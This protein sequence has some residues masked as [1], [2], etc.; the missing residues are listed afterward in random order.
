MEDISIKQVWEQALDH[1]EKNLDPGKFRATFSRTKPMSYKDGVFTIAAP[2]EFDKKWIL[3]SYYELTTETISSILGSETKLSIEVDESIIKK[4]LKPEPITEED[5]DEA[6]FEFEQ[7]A[8]SFQEPEQDEVSKILDSVSSRKSDNSKPL[9]KTLGFNP[10]YTFDSFIVG[11]SNSFAHSAALAVAESPGLK[12]NPLFIWGDSGLG[13]THLLQSIGNYVTQSFPNKKVIYVTA[14]QFSDAYTMSVQEKTI[15]D[16]KDLFRSVDVLLIDDIQ[17]IE[18]KKGTIEQFF[19]TF[20]Y[21]SERG[22]QIVIA[23]DRSPEEIALDERLASRLRSGLPV[24]ILP[25]SYEVSLAIIRQFLKNQRFT[26]TKEAEA[27]VAEH[28]SGNIR[29][30]EGILTRIIAYSEL[31]RLTEVTVQTVQDVAGSMLVR[32]EAKPISIIEIQKEVAKYLSVTHADMIG[33][34]RKQDIVQ[35]R[36]I[37]MYL[38]QELTDKSLPQIGKEFGNSHHTTVMHAVG[39]I[40]EKIKKDKDLYNIVDH[41]ISRLKS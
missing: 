9:R 28:S 40:R 20:N 33:P 24:D 10:K 2:N 6:V 41:L 34:K 39:K 36:H 18:G 12:Y 7:Q 23:A 29:E 17:F 8:I 30:M 35:A 13:K 19:H 11:D 25:P 37:A 26:F 5:I 14:E 27:Y 4:Q 15:Q 22:N 32:R 21:L 31:S 38:S 16:F 3:S 1:I